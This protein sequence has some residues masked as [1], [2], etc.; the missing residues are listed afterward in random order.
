M[1][2]GWRG[3]QT[4]VHTARG[5]QRPGGRRR[6]RSDGRTSCC[7]GKMRGV[8]VGGCGWLWV[9]VGAER[10]SSREIDYGSQ[11]Q[12]REAKE[13]NFIGKGGRGEVCRNSNSEGRGG[14]GRGGEERG[15]GV[16]LTWKTWTWN[17]NWRGMRWHP[18]APPIN[19]QQTT[20][21]KLFFF[22]FFLLWRKERITLFENLKFLPSLIGW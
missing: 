2:R 22:F 11:A 8:A 7:A 5:R 9:A 1:T 20:N 15:F 10:T 12:K 14:T 13:T 17:W 21:N 19:K 16:G 4:G 6:Q 18:E 3:H